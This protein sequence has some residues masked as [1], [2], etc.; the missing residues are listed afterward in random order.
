MKKIKVLKLNN[1]GSTMIET[2]VAFLVLMIVMAALFKMVSFSSELRMRS[3]DT[4][5]VLADFNQELYSKGSYSKIKKTKFKTDLTLSEGKQG[6]LFYI[7]PADTADGNTDNALWVTDINA[8]GF[9]YDESDS[10]IKD[11]NIIAP[12]A[13]QFVHEKDDSE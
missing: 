6:P 1:K 10:L 3:V 8:Y 9:T 2:L 4:G 11:E 7:V 13:M 5:N 12:K